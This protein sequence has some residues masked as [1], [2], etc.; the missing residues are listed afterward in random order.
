MSIAYFR[1][2]ILCFLSVPW[3]G[4]GQ[5]HWPGM[6]EHQQDEESSW[7]QQ[8]AVGGLKPQTWEENQVYEDLLRTLSSSAVTGP[9]AAGLHGPQNLDFVLPGRKKDEI[10]CNG[11]GNLRNRLLT[12]KEKKANT[13]C[14]N[15]YLFF[16]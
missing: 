10:L 14:D 8:P 12:Q 13:L 7:P 16:V 4:R 9:R 11:L 3:D 15:L 2:A 5:P 6:T 1:P